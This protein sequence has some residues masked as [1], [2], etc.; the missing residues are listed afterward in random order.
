MKKTDGHN[1]TFGPFII[2]FIVL[3]LLV[4]AGLY[5]W[6]H[7][8]NSDERQKMETRQRDDISSIKMDLDATDVEELNR[9]LQDI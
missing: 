8:L 6:A 3:L 1:R 5:V 7:I 9:S 2:S 4:L